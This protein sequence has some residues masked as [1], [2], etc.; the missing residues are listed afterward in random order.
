MCGNR[1]CF[2]NNQDI[3]NDPIVPELLN[4]I[5]EINRATESCF[6][7][8]MYWEAQLEKKDRKIRELEE[9]IKAQITGC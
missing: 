8:D 4:A 6:S 2:F 3:V 9:A 5:E 7:L 1:F